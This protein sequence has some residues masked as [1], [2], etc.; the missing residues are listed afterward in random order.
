MT[1]WVLLTVSGAMLPPPPHPALLSRA[2]TEGLIKKCFSISSNSL[3][4]VLNYLVLK[5]TTII[6]DICSIHQMTFIV[7][8]CS[9]HDLTLIAEI[10]ETSIFQLKEVLNIY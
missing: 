3:C 9:I 1:A 4:G 7:D 2:N 10:C 8:I 6:A 5:Y